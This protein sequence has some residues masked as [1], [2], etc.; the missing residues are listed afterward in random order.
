MYVEDEIGI[1]PYTLPIYLDFCH[2]TPLRF[3]G[4]G[5]GGWVEDMNMEIEMGIV[6]LFRCGGGGGNVDLMLLGRMIMIGEFIHMDL[7]GG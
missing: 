2:P 7:R 6:K 5:G 1:I 3:F 4:E